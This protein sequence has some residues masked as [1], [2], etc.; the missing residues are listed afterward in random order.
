MARESKMEYE[1]EKKIFLAAR[2][3]VYKQKP[4][5]CWK[6]WLLIERMQQSDCL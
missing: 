3:I 5:M 6:G 2:K 1:T 4:E